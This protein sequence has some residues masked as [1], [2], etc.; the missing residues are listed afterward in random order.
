MSRKALIL[1]LTVLLLAATATEIQRPLDG[2]K[3][4]YLILDEETDLYHLV[5]RTRRGTAFD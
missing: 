4:Y 5:I 1:F 2:D 3:L